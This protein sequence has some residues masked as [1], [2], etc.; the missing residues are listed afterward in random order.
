MKAS[1]ES[2]FSAF[3]E[4]VW[5]SDCCVM[6]KRGILRVTPWFRGRRGCRGSAR[7]CV[8]RHD[9]RLDFVMIAGQRFLVSA[10]ETVSYIYSRFSLTSQFSLTV[11]ASSCRRLTVL[12]VGSQ[13]QRASPDSS[14][15]QPASAISDPPSSSSNNIFQQQQH[16]PPPSHP[17]SSHPARQQQLLPRV[18]QRLPPTSTAARLSNFY[19]K[20]LRFIMEN[21]SESSNLPSNPSVESENVQEEMRSDKK[22]KQRVVSNCWDHFTKL[23]VG[24]VAKAKCNHCGT[25]LSC[26]SGT[27]HLNRH[28]RQI[29]G[30]NQSTIEEVF[31]NKQ[32]LVKTESGELGIQKFDPLVARQKLTTVVV[33]HELPFR[34]VEYE[35]FREF[36]DY[37]NPL[38]KHM[39]RNTL[40]SEIFKIYN[41]EKGKAMNLLEVNNSRVAITTD[42]WTA[43]NQKKGYMVVTGHFIDNSWHLQSRILRFIYVQA[44]HTAD[45]ISQIL[46]KCLM[47]WNLDRKLSTVTLDNCSTNDAMV[48]RLKGLLSTESMILSGNFF[49]MRCAAHI[50]NLIVKDGLSVIESGITRVRD[51][52]SYWSSSPKRVEKFEVACRQIQID[53]KKLGLDCPTR[54]NSTFAMLELAVKY[55][56]VF[57]RLQTL[58]PQ[59][60]CLPSSEEWE[61]AKQMLDYLRPFSKLT[62]MFSGTTYP[63]A[64]L[65]FPLVCKMRI[66]LKGWQTSDVPAV[67]NMADNMIG[68]FLKYWDEISGVLGMAVILDPRYKMMLINYY[69]PKI[70]VVGL[71]NQLKRVREL[72]NEM[73]NYYEAKSATTRYGVVGESSTALVV[74]SDQSHIDFD[75]IDDMGDFDAYATQN[76][77]PISSKSDLDMY[78]ED[79][80]VKRTPDFDVLQWW[81]MNKGKY[82][83]LAEM[84]KDLLAIPV[85]TVASESAFSTGGR[86]LSPHRSRLHP[87]TL[88]AIMCSQ[89]WL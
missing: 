69:Y 38:V 16:Q 8:L 58:E 46:V 48:A 21:V 54:W 10:S 26:G 70:Y 43:C 40:K 6:G 45:C 76:S 55:K 78:L 5:G 35:S 59:Y 39:S 28:T 17:P 62:E 63:T 24:S 68:K 25:I 80:L 74:P 71:E 42:M 12:A 36:V 37:C 41:V 89:H 33:K 19:R 27:N 81:K 61:L 50:L 34:F 44:P 14:S 60:K 13:Q 31:E 1:S 47:D 53:V 29:H 51:S 2:Q 32:H 15:V 22:R 85:T 23:N 87:D 7:S 88:E 73:M 65:F 20:L 3:S 86:T 66:A 75:N 64:N 9:A 79:P 77:Q 18:Q 83:I 72:C 82:P 52:V 67:K 4:T 49:H 11:T 30:F 57:S 56:S 84:A